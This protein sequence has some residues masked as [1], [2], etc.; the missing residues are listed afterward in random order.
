[1]GTPKT[2]GPSFLNRASSVLIAAIALVMVPIHGAYADLVKYGYTNSAGVKTDAEPGVGL[3][4]PSA[5]IS[6]MVSGGVDRKLRIAVTAD[7]AATPIFTKESSKVLGASDVISYKGEN[8]YAEEFVSPKLPD[9]RYTVKTEILSSAGAVV[10]TENVPLVIDTAAPV[11]GTFAPRP[12]TWGDPVLTG[13]VW[14]LGLAAIDALTYSSFVLDGFYDS[15]GIS[16]VTAKVYR[17]SGSL[18][19]EHNVLFRRRVEPPQFSIEQISSPTPI[20]TR[21]SGLSLS[22]PT[23]QETLR[24]LSVRK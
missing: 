6:F 23:R 9:G 14:K 12:Y 13:E 8:Y 21:F 16:K 17:E 22:L 10:Q 5:G 3:I 1:M 11:A 24:Q 15:S 20:W 2:R 7:S 19:K 4:N 18:Y